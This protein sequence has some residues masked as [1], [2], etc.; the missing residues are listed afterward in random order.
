MDAYV[1]IHLN[2]N[3]GVDGASAS[4]T[5]FADGIHL[6]GLFNYPTVQSGYGVLGELFAAQM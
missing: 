6:T 4:S 1:P 2:A 5:Y 3:I